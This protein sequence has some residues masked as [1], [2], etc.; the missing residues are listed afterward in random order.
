[1]PKLI[2]AIEES[3]DVPLYGIVGDLHYPVPNGRIRVAGMDAQRRLAS[4]SGP[5]KPINIDAVHSEME[6]LRSKLQFIALGSHDTSDQVLSDFKKRFGNDYY[7]VL[8]GQNIN[9]K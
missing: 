5:F 1:M 3:F 9:V 2:E 4:G 6:M 8:V 7:H